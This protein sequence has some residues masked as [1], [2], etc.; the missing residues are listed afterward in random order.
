MIKA[1]RRSDL[2]LHVRFSNFL[3]GNLLFS[4]IEIII[5]VSIIVEIKR[6]KTTS[7]W[8]QSR[9]KKEEIQMRNVIKVTDFPEDERRQGR[10]T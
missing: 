5:A 4:I 6:M 8:D 3:Q 1:R 10:H 7:G 2:K 9:G